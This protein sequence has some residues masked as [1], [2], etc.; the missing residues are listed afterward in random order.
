MGVELSVEAIKPADLGASER[1]LWQ[2]F[3]QASPE[4]ASPYFDFRYALAAGDIAPHSAV[5]VIH[6]QGRIEGFLPFQRRG[7]MIQPLAAPLTDYH[8]LIAAP[9]ARIDLS[10][11][12]RA[13]KADTFSFTAMRSGIDAARSRTALRHAMIA[14]LSGGFDAYLARRAAVNADFLKDKRRRE[15]ALKRDHGPISLSFP[16][17]DPAQVCDIIA[18]KREQMRRTGQHDIFACGWTERLVRRLM[19]EDEPD[20]GARLAVLRAG[21]TV[22]AAEIG[23]RAGGVYHLWFPV[24]DPAYARY[25]PGA[26]MTLETL[27]AL[28]SKGVHHVDFGLEGEAYK[29]DFA[30]PGAVVFEGS[31]AG[32]A[33]VAASARLIDQ[34][35]GKAPESFKAARLRMRRRLDRIAAC[36]P[37]PVDWLK[38][39]VA[40]LGA[41]AGRA[42]T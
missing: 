15:R 12:V 8:G 36:E 22:V 16:E 29:R 25:S 24:Y 31:I 6:R 13:L 9:D 39:A 2:G 19:E 7:S 32:S 14:D 33:W 1:A 41:A 21:D 23:L 20:F 37:H 40:S 27:R 38:G 10:A 18:R 17:R 5:A 35:A 11:V 42:R 28:P 3:V 4:L 30:D 34:V 26:L